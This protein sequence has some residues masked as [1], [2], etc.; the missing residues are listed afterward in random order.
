MKLP[1][2]KSMGVTLIGSIELSENNLAINAGRQ[3]D[4]ETSLSLIDSR[5]VNAP[6]VEALNISE[7]GSVISQNAAEF[8][9]GGR[10]SGADSVEATDVRVNE[11]LTLD[12]LGFLDPMV[13]VDDA[14]SILEF[15]TAE[16]NA[17]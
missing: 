5:V 8:Q 12:G 10:L 14:A 4:L 2:L 16:S 9:A 15:M 3:F 13:I 17:R 1:V 6:Q 7:N 11:A